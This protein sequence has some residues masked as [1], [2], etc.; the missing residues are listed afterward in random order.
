MAIPSVV[1]TPPPVPLSG[2]LAIAFSQQE[3]TPNEK[4]IA[5]DASRYLVASPYTDAE[6]LL[7]LETLDV[8][9][10]LL[11]EALA[12]MRPLRDDYAT[13]PYVDIF[14]WEE[15]I[16]RIRQ[17]ATARG[18]SFKETSWY[19]VA[20]RSQYKPTTDHPDLGVLDKAAHAEAMASGGFLK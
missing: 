16:D 13:A 2:K 1:D 4:S 20:F 12:E 8:E 3:T 18:I 6:H 15:M 11:A 17:L 5:I 10:G 14:N 7:D 9:N 19:I